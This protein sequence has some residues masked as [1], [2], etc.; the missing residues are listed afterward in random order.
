MMS[1]QGALK[2]NVVTSITRS[3]HDGVEIISTRTG[4]SKAVSVSGKFRDRLRTKTYKI[5]H[6]IAEQLLKPP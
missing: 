1:T 6:C 2:I 4:L 5:E 3:P